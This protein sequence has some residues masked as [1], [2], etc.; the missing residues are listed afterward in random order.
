MPVTNY[1]QGRIII[2]IF[3]D[4]VRGVPHFFEAVYEFI[5]TEEV[6]EDRALFKQIAPYFLLHRVAQTF[7]QSTHRLKYILVLLILVGLL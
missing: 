6:L 1:V 4:F 3:N 7:G 2:S 5:Y